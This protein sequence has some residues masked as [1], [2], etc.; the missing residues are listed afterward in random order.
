MVPSFFSLVHLTVQEIPVDGA[1]TPL[2]LSVKVKALKADPFQ[3]G[4]D[5]HIRL[6]SHLLC[7]VQAMMTYLV[8]LQ[9]GRPLSPVVLSDWLRPILF[10]ARV[11]E[12]LSSHNFRTGAAT[13][14][15]PYGV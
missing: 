2:C 11:A 4:S 1:S 12:N 9:D 10:T 5:I 7:A 15:A 13:V 3:K 6:G 14:A 8:Q